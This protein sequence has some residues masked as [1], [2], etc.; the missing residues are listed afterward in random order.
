MFG[1]VIFT[2]KVILCPGYIF[3]ALSFTV[4]IYTMETYERQLEN[5]VKHLQ[6]LFS[7]LC[8]YCVRLPLFLDHAVSCICSSFVVG[9]ICHWWPIKVTNKSLMCG[10]II[11]NIKMDGREMDYTAGVAWEISD[12]FLCCENLLVLACIVTDISSRGPTVV[13]KGSHFLTATFITKSV[14]LYYK[15][16]FWGSITLRATVVMVSTC[17][18]GQS[19]QTQ[20][21]LLLPP[22][23][24]PPKIWKR[25]ELPSLAADFP[26]NEV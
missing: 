19:H 26:F 14:W 15:D 25:Q 3:K 12:H 1:S 8:V 23:F 24:L 20:N 16:T 7:L 21:I 6:Q 22:S 17:V 9:F 2:I 10:C 4:V 5:S 13:S 18:T 11:K